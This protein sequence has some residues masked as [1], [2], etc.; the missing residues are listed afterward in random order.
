[1]PT[2]HPAIV[3]TSKIIEMYESGMSCNQIGKAIGYSERVPYLRLKEAGISLRSR[4]ESLKLR[5]ASDPPLPKV[6]VEFKC[7]QCGKVLMLQPGRARRRKFCSLQC[8]VIWRK[9]HGQFTQPGP[10]V[11][12]ICKACECK[13]KVLPHLADKRQFCSAACARYHQHIHNRRWANTTIELIIRAMLTG[14]GIEYTIQWRL[15]NYS[16]DI[17]IA[18]QGKAIECDGDYWHKLPITVQTDLHKEKAFAKAGIPVLHLT[19][20]EIREDIPG[21]RDKIVEFLSL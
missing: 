12:L 2:G 3:D 8:S 20:T 16:T 15:G 18:S 7:R 5:F 6:R 9:E 1:M 17:Y 10:R 19:G 4:S 13:F 11:T 14:M 21:C